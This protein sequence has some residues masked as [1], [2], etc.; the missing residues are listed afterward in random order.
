MLKSGG[1]DGPSQVGVA[2]A[3][4]ARDV[5][6]PAEAQLAEAETADTEHEVET[7]RARS[8]GRGGSTPEAS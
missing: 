3:M 2:A 8:S 4:R 6:R 7:Y 5:S 1:R